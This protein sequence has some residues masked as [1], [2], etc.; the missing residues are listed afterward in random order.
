MIETICLVLHYIN[1]ALRIANPFLF[2][3][4]TCIWISLKM[5][6]EK[7]L[8]RMYLRCFSLEKQIDYLV[9]N[10]KVDADFIRYMQGIH[11]EY[12]R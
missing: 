3:G 2:F 9:N 6:M 8:G 12:K 4:A 11:N 1:D 10:E 5:R 7:E